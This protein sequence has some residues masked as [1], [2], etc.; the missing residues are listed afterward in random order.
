MTKCMTE[1][2]EG[3]SVI[4]YLANAELSLAAVSPYLAVHYRVQS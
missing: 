3:N 1:F 2:D 4:K